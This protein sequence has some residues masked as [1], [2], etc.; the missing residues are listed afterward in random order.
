[1]LKT[2][3]NFDDFDVLCLDYTLVTVNCVATSQSSLT[4]MMVRIRGSY[5]QIAVFQVSEILSFPRNKCNISI[6]MRY[7][8]WF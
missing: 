2:P 5:P 4:G 3:T 6:V 8:N 7:T 1:M